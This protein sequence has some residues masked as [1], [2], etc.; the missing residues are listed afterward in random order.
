MVA[1]QITPINGLFWDLEVL[2][3]LS[4]P[5]YIVTAR[6]WNLFLMY[7]VIYKSWQY[8]FFFFLDIVVFIIRSVSIQ[9]QQWSSKN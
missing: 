2:N 5:S 1:V 8:T 9:I 3:F 6:I 4:S 7:R